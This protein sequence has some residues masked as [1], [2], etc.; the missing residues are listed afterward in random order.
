MKSGAQLGLTGKERRVHTRHRAEEQY[1]QQMIDEFFEPDAHE[2]ERNRPIPVHHGRNLRSHDSGA[3]VLL[4]EATTDGERLAMPLEPPGKAPQ[5]GAAARPAPP[6]R[7]AATAQKVSTTRHFSALPA[8]PQRAT[9]PVVTPALE[10][11]DDTREWTL[12]GLLCGAAVGGAIAAALL[13][14]VQLA[15]G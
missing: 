2:L 4:A 10:Q 6:D 14:I 9:A 13:L 5:R 1:V 7:A 15:L 3:F 12:R 11:R 8:R